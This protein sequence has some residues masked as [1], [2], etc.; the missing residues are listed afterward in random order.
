MCSSEP[1]TV[2]VL[3]IPSSSDHRLPLV[4]NLEGSLTPVGG[5]GRDE[6][7][8][9]LKGTANLAFFDPL[10][11][12]VQPAGLVLSARPTEWDKMVQTRDIAGKRQITLIQRRCW[13]IRIFGQAQD[14]M[15]VGD[16]GLRVFQPLTGHWAE[17]MIAGVA[18][19]GL[20]ERP[21][22][23][24]TGQ[25]HREPEETRVRPVWVSASIAGLL[26]AVVAWAFTRA[27]SLHRR[28]WAARGLTSLGKTSAAASKPFLDTAHKLME[29]HA[30]QAGI[31]G[32]I[33]GGDSELDRFWNEIER[34]RFGRQSPSPELRNEILQF[35]KNLLANPKSS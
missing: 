23:G 21:V 26:I 12:M 28:D 8:L 4:G 22:A 13:G 19:A 31:L 6:V 1:V 17:K 35:L 20:D 33:G 34:L 9:E 3:P 32:R 29:R 5:S 7:I 24:T 27:R 25:P 2:D 11:W 10:Q 15:R 18:L 30:A 16:I 14:R